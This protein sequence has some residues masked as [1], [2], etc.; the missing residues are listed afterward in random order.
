MIVYPSQ[1]MATPLTA[2]RRERVLPV[3]GEILV[4]E[5]E[6]VEPFQ[7]IGRA[8]VPAGFQIVNVARDLGVPPAK[9]AKYLK[10]K[11]GQ[12]VKK[13]DLV[14]EL[15]GISALMAVLFGMAVRPSR[16]PLDGTVTDSGGGR[17]LIE[18]FPKEI[19][20]RANYHGVVSRVVPEWGVYLRITGAVIQGN[21]GNGK[22]SA[23]VL[24][25][26]SKSNDKPIRARSIDGSCTGAVLIG[27]S[28]I[29]ASVLEKAI[30]IQARGIISGSI[31]P[32]AIEMANQA[33]FPVIV[34][35]GAGVCP[36]C[37]HI[38]RLLATNDG[39]EATLNA[40]FKSHWGVARPE[41]VI[42][43]PAEPGMEFQ[44]ALD[45]PLK[46]GDTVRAIRTPHLGTVGT[47]VEF[48]AWLRTSAGS[49]LPAAKVK[50]EG[51]QE[52]IL[53]PLS[54]LEVLR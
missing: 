30:E 12:K 51:A 11:P 14:A 50:T 16:S 45:R 19:E 21:W 15:R 33:T 53:I 26:M 44:E 8:L 4:K 52:N 48:P 41:V 13:D 27:G 42:S 54:N 1:T 40:S 46:V 2:I 25:L 17:I 34:T 23:G 3:A 35:E 7:V 38:Y 37:P 39:R 22:E 47:V 32:G 24:K 5:G 20:L 18:A 29:D 43:L 28:R 6:S 36:M 10:V 9:A 49:Q 31:D